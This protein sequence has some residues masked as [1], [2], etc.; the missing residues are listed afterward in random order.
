MIN[1]CYKNMYELLKE[2]VTINIYSYKIMSKH[3]VFVKNWICQGYLFI[4]K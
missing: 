3:S 1:D 2:N 4:I